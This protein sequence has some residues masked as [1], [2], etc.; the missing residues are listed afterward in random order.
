MLHFESSKEV[1]MS[2]LWTSMERR[3]LMDAMEMDWMDPMD[4]MDLSEVYL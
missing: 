1:E 3:D 2:P 4:E